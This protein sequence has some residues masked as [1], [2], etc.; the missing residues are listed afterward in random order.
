MFSVGKDTVLKLLA[1]LG[2]VC[3]D[4]HDMAVRNVPAK[5][6]ECDEIWSFCYAKKKNVPKDKENITGIGDL[7]T[8]TAIEAQS[9][10][11]ISYACGKRDLNWAKA[12]IDDLASRVSTRLQITS[13]GLRFYAE[14]I[15]GAFGAEVDYAMLIKQYG[16]PMQE[17][18]SARYSPA[19]CIGTTVGIKSGNPDPNHICTSYVERQNLTMRMSMRRFTRLTNG[20]SKKYENHCHNLAIYFMYYNFCRIHSSLR[21][22]PA[23]E[24]G[25]ASH[26]WNIAELISLLEKKEQIAA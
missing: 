22:T 14:A 18:S 15:E 4:Y 7:W 2:T 16:A 12:F 26:A 6:V 1:E 19:Q 21:V 9:K 5:H 13:D 11:I 23:M 24:A 8:W 10:L 25:I 20:F 3:A 17:D